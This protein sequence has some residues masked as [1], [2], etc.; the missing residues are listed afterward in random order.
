MIS[1]TEE[2]I[3]REHPKHNASLGV[4]LSLEVRERGFGFALIDN[5]VALR[6]CGT[7]GRRDRP[8][9][10]R[11]AGQSSLHGFTRL[12]QEGNPNLVVIGSPDTQ[13]ARQ[14]TRRF[15]QAAHER[16]VRVERV[17]RN[18]LLDAF[19]NCNKH[20]IAVAVSK[21]FPQLGGHV[22]PNRRPWHSE[23][24]WTVIFDAIACGLAYL[25]S[26]GRM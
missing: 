6:T 9:R 25:H 18:L 7:R 24:Y 16:H 14:I 5:A 11:A 21:R 3:A 8:T 13:E 15:A 12:L 22:P 10:G 2:T 19:P 4:I 23:Y 1:T 17:S 20:E 26:A